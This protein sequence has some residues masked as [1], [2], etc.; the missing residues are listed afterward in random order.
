MILP[1]KETKSFIFASIIRG[2]KNRFIICPV[3]RQVMKLGFH[4]F[5][6]SLEANPRV[7]H[8]PFRS[9]SQAMASHVFSLRGCVCEN[10]C[11][12]NDHH[13]LIGESQSSHMFPIGSPYFAIETHKNWRFHPFSVCQEC[14]RNCSPQSTAK[15]AA[16]STTSGAAEAKDTMAE[17][18]HGWAATLWDVE[19]L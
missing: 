4:G 5:A 11:I 13:V 8:A 6:P 7:S 2:P 17:S 1:A 12:I 10:R 19:E 15:A 16:A 9:Q 3:K 14:P 18:G